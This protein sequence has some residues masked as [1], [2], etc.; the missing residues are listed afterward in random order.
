MEMAMVAWAVIG[1]DSPNTSPVL[2]EVVPLPFQTPPTDLSRSKTITPMVAAD[3]ISC[4]DVPLIFVL[5]GV[6]YS[7]TIRRPTSG[8]EAQFH[9]VRRINM[10]SRQ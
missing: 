10:A 8:M 9:A 7:E 3:A 6:R 5:L 2:H 4:D 1:N